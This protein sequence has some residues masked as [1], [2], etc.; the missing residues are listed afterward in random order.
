MC[1]GKHGM[2]PRG[3]LPAFHNRTWHYSVKKTMLAC[4]TEAGATAVAAATA[5]VQHSSVR[6]A[7]ARGAIDIAQIILV[8]ENSR[9]IH[10]AA[11]YT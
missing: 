6:A 10:E 4:C 8:L 3:G 1:L 2:G 11:S 7:D 9:A 5:A